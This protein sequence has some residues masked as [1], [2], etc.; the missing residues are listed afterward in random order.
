MAV[1]ARTCYQNLTACLHETLVPA[2]APVGIIPG[3][4][5]HGQLSQIPLPAPAAPQDKP[6]TSHG[7]LPKLHP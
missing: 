2:G 3:P 7:H 4:H 6:N 1:H 5:P